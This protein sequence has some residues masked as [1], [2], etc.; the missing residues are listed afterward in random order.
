[1]PGLLAAVAT[2]ALPPAAHAD[3]EPGCVPAGAETVSVSAGVTVWHQTGGPL[4]AC[5]GFGENLELSPGSESN[6]FDAGA[7]ST[8][9]ALTDSC[10]VV[11]RESGNYRYSSLDLSISVINLKTRTFVRSSFP[12]GGPQPTAVTRAIAGQACSSVA[13]ELQTPIGTFLQAIDSRGETYA[14]AG[15]SLEQLASELQGPV[16]G[17]R[18]VVASVGGA[19]LSA[20]PT[21]KKSLGKLTLWLRYGKLGVNEFPQGITVL[22]GDQVL[23]FPNPISLRVPNQTRLLAVPLSTTLRARLRA[24]KSYRIEVISC[25]GGCVNQKRTVAVGRMR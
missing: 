10:A 3:P 1:M 12:L 20:P 22:V 19:K 9:V 16:A 17:A 18:P 11:A 24:G 8:L 25:A 4:V 21:I 15:Q 14:A 13:I 23:R 7:S 2:A 6:F 5:G